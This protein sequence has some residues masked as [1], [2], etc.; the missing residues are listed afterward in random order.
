MAQAPKRSLRDTVTQLV[1]IGILI[2]ILIVAVIFFRQYVDSH[3]ANAAYSKPA[4]NFRCCTAFNTEELYH[5]GEVVTLAW[6]PVEELPGDYT[7][8]TI[9]LSG[10]LSH[11]FIDA[12]DIKS[13][14][15]AGT[16]SATTGPFS[17]AAGQVRVSNRSGA[18]P[19]ST[20]EIPGNA[21]TGY[22][23][24]VTTASQRGFSV[25]SALIIEVRR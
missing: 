21:T 11:S 15:K 13:S 25:T 24:L 20:I 16:F 23:D 18:T 2:V 5:P 19:V 3:D 1:V 4:F 10:F 22:Y 6:T 9:T 8:Q 7:S 12:A 17:A 14:T